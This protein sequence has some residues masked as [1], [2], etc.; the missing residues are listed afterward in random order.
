MRGRIVLL[1]NGFD[2]SAGSKSTPGLAEY[3][4]R[5][6]IRNIAY[7]NWAIYG[8]RDWKNNQADLAMDRMLE[9]DFGVTVI[10]PKS[11]STMKSTILNADAVY[12]K[13]GNPGTLEYVLRKTGA[14][15][16]LREFHL[17]G[18]PI[19]GVSAGGI[20]LGSG[21]LWLISYYA[22]KPLLGSGYWW[23]GKGICREGLGLYPEA[24]V[25]HHE[26]SEFSP[27]VRKVAGALIGV[28]GFI[29]VPDGKMK[30]VDC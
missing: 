4:H 7:I 18:K 29:F 1:A 13:G 30:I 14:D 25:P 3:M 10:D 12:L 17:S 24:F 11:R 19:F 23:A 21:R 8:F 6:K 27:L 2:D 20:V 22:V 5:S 15:H 16:L 26:Q 28:S 9:A